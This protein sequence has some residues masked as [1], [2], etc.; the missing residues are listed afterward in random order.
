M[1]TATLAKLVVKLEA[2]SARLQSQLEKSEKRAK[3]W[4]KKTTN[5]IRGVKKAFIGLAS[6]ATIGIFAKVVKDS[7]AAADRIGKVSDA[8]ALTTSEY[9]KLAFAADI[10]G[11][12]QEQFNSNMTAFVKR[13]GEA[14]AGTGPLVSFLKKYDEVLLQAIKNTKSQAEAFDLVANAIKKAKTETDQ[15]AIANAAFS[16]AGIGM[17]NVM[18]DGAAGLDA[19]RAKAEK[20]GIVIDE[21][22]VR[23]AEEA[24]D[25]LTIMATV[26]KNK[27]ITQVV[28]LAPQIV[29]IGEAFADAIPSITRFFETIS[30]AET[31]DNLESSIASLEQRQDRFREKLQTAEEPQEFTNKLFRLITGT[32]N[33]EKIR[34]Q[35]DETTSLIEQYQLKIQEL[36]AAEEERAAETSGT[37]SPSIGAKQAEN[38]ALTTLEIEHAERIKKILIKD[39]KDREKIEKN[40]SRTITNMRMNVFQHGANLLRAL[41]G[42][43]KVAAIAV[44]A[45]EKG[46]AI[47]QTIMNTNV[48]AIRALAELGPIAGPPAAATIKSIGAASIGLIAATGFAQAAGIGG[49]GASLGT[50]AN[51]VNVQPTQ[52]ETTD[53]L[54]SQEQRERRLDVHVTIESVVPQDPEQLDQLAELLADNF[55]NGGK[56]P[57]AE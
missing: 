17:V 44:I 3:R 37:A 23:S 50:P 1:A 51:P 42:E 13:V 20:L 30:G 29:K 6:A 28:A 15:A 2:D 33:P 4:E 5:S 21:K 54:S 10:G 36:R 19:M 56:S 41:A 12:K 14:R 35:L 38:D 34:E 52:F 9:Q 55:R 57:V 7:I 49:G 53:V 39:A 8:V 45:I 47:A 27:V 31:I 43:S 18:R 32:D 22:T 48:A 46:L 26:I 11:V 40:V 24:N 16:R 25:Q